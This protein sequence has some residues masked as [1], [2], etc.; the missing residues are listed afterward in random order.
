MFGKTQGLSVQHPFR[1]AFSRGSV[2]FSKVS[3]RFW[4]VFVRFCKFLEGFWNVYSFYNVHVRWQHL[5]ADF[6]KL[7]EKNNFLTG[8]GGSGLTAYGTGLTP[9]KEILVGALGATLQAAPPAR[10]PRPGAVRPPP[11][12]PL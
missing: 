5:P 1:K 6:V 11:V 9:S 2:R 10:P 12:A 3:V 8:I 4:K 7:P